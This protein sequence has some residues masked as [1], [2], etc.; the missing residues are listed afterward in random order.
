MIV[1][2]FSP[3]SFLLYIKFAQAYQL[4]FGM[5]IGDEDKSWA[6]HVI[7]GTCRYNLEG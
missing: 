5:K 4:Y 2:A 6:S 3:L 7:C 1:H